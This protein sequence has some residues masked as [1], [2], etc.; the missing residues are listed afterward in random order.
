MMVTR[1]DVDTGRLDMGAGLVVKYD[2]FMPI[3]FFKDKIT[4]FKISEICTDLTL[5]NIAI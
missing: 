2:Q 4:F 5:R 1:A 3:R